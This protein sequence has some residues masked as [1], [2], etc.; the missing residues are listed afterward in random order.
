MGRHTRT[1]K[2]YTLP[3]VE[4]WATC[5]TCASWYHRPSRWA[6]LKRWLHG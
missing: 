2:T 1:P 4:T 3:L 6:R 5:A